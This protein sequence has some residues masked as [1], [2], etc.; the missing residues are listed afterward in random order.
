MSLIG[1]LTHSSIM[2]K[3]L[4]LYISLI[5]SFVMSCA[6]CVEVSAVYVLGTN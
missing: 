2:S 6:F 3:V 4:S 1:K 5:M